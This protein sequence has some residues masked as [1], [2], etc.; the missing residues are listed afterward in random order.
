[1]GDGD[2]YAA[3]G[4]FGGVKVEVHFGG[5]LPEWLARDIE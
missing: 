5:G 4:V 2:L 1:M 3:I